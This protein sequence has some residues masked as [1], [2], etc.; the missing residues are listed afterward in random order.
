MC[1]T[2]KNIL[3]KLKGKVINNKVN[4]EEQ[5]PCIIYDKVICIEQIKYKLDIS[6]E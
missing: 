2:G 5:I 3:R 1:C 6:Q 4:K